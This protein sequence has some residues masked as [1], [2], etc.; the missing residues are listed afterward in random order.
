M[1]KRACWMAATFAAFCAQQE[2]HPLLVTVCTVKPGP[3]VGVR[4]DTCRG[5]TMIYISHLEP[6]YLSRVEWRR[7]FV[8]RR[9]KLLYIYQSFTQNRLG[10]ILN[11]RI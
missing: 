1:S 5:G 8:S 2:A 3:H 11:H 10:L 7:K 6:H 9:N 4:Q